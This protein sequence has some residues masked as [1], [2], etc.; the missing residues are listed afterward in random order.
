M[1]RALAF[2]IVSHV[3]ATSASLAAA[4]FFMGL[5]DL[6]GGGF[7]STANG[8]NANGTVVVGQGTVSGSF[9]NRGFRWTLSD[10]K[11]IDLGDLPGGRNKYFP[12]CHRR[13][14]P[15]VGPRDAR[16]QEGGLGVG[17]AVPPPCFPC[18]QSAPQP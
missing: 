17:R 9:S 6:P 7:N 3:I 12:P 13:Q 8:V 10:R 18:N 16:A 14:E 2:G 1:H 4:P 15:P 5:G 11:M